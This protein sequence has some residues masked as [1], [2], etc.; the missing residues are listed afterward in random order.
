M[1]PRVN[2]PSRLCVGAAAALLLTGCLEKVTDSPVPLDERFYAS[3][4][5]DP[6]AAGGGGGGSGG[7]E[8][9]FVDHEGETTLLTGSVKAPEAGPVQL[10]VM[11]PAPDAPGGVTR[12][13]VLQLADVGTFELKVPIAITRLSLQTFQDLDGD[14]PS[15][16]DPY[17]NV[18]VTL[19]AAAPV[20]LVLVAGA[21][22]KPRGGGPAGAAPPGG[23][24]GTPT[25]PDPAQPGA[26]GGDPGAGN[27]HGN[28]TLRFPDGPRV[29]LKG[30]ITA[31]RT[32]PVILDV[33]QP[34]ANARGGRSYLGRTT[35]SVGAFRVEVPRGIGPLELEAY[36]DLTGDS[37]SA[38]DPSARTERPV[39]VGSVDTD[40]GTL[41]IP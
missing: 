37:R 39:D 20:E 28:D 17:T 18:D 8:A 6:G 38:D 25:A 12:A 15:E 9:P 32:L 16:M 1:V 2:V 23:G 19:P 22:G 41:A 40:A 29:A 4:P 24:D 5:D 27:S 36:Q 3:A 26:P 35:V 11:V 7:G 21:R 33:F 31:S 30:T 10:D 34:D 13:G 14:G